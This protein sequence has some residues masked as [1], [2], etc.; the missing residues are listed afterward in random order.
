MRILL[1]ISFL[2][3]VGLIPVYGSESIMISIS[4]TMDQAIFDGKWTNFKEWKK[5][6]LNTL[7]YDDGMVIQLRTAHQD[8]FVYVLADVVSDKTPDKG[9]DRAVICF[10]TGNEKSTIADEND[11]CFYASLSGKTQK[12]LQGGS[13]IIVT[14]NFKQ[15]SSPEGYIGLGEVSDENDRYSKI[16][17]AT[18]EFRIPTD[19]IGRSNLYG[20]YLGVYDHNSKTVYNWPTDITVEHYRD[21]PSPDKWGEI[22]SPDKSLPE[23]NLPLLI[24][25]PSLILIIYFTRF[26]NKFVSNVSI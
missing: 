1:V 20:F 4:P 10:D 21:I 13:P 19:F 26:K 22:I 6:S 18:Y 25:I 15:I 2:I 23:F 11:Y 8:N 14:S 3:S 12:I 24:L 5:S 9:Q 17:H 7:T 16:P